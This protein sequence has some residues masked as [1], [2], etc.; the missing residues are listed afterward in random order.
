MQ[1]RELTHLRSP[2][3][4]RIQPGGMVA[5]IPMPIVNTKKPPKNHP[6]LPML[7]PL[8]HVR[9]KTGAEHQLIPCE[10]CCLLNVLAVLKGCGSFCSAVCTHNSRR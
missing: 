8:A 5:K 4:E 1:L 7:F 2:T 10:R 3:K 6:I 9:K